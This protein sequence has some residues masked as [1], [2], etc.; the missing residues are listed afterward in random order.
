MLC[1]CL[2]YADVYCVC[3]RVPCTVVYVWVAPF[4]YVCFLMHVCVH[5]LYVNKCVC[6]VL[7]VSG[8][9]L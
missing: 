1:V 8:C 9:A 3:T 7:C 2:L 6:H 5:V 4:C